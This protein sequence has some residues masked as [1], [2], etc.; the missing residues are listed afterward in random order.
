MPG[1][2]GGS[3][4]ARAVVAQLLAASEMNWSLPWGKPLSK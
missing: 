1:F 4:S 3:D 2:T